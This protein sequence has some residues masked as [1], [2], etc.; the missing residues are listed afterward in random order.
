M[1]ETIQDITRR[2][3]AL[4]DT[5]NPD[6]ISVCLVH[7]KTEDGSLDLTVINGQYGALLTPDLE[8]IAVIPNEAPRSMGAMEIFWQGFFDQGIWGEDDYADML[9]HVATETAAGRHGFVE[10]DEMPVKIQRGALKNAIAMLE[11]LGADDAAAAPLVAELKE[12]A[13]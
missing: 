8:L 5:S 11:K 13:A 9:D 6:D 10:R 7:R 12:L 4:R 1:T 3:I 2:H